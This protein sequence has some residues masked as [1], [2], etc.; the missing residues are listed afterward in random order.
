[1][2]Q[3]VHKKVVYQG[4]SRILFSIFSLQVGGS[5]FLVAYFFKH[6]NLQLVMNLKSV[7][8]DNLNS[9]NNLWCIYVTPLAFFIELY[10]KRTLW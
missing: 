9:Y 7:Y 2:L 4:F 6:R 5:N 10:L 8:F 3:G 1:M